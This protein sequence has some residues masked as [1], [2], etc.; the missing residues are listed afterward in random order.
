MIRRWLGVRPIHLCILLSAFTRAKSELHSVLGCTEPLNGP[1]AEY[2]RHFKLKSR[3]WL[4]N[5]CVGFGYFRAAFLQPDHRKPYV[6]KIDDY[7]EIAE[8]IESSLQVSNGTQMGDPKKG[9]HVVRG[10]SVARGKEF[11]QSLLMGSDCFQLCAGSDSGIF[12][13]QDGVGE[14]F[15]EHRFLNAYLS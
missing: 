3:P 5:I 10:E 14:C 13:A 12:G 11:P 2:P 4:R 1:C 6:A 7:R 15:E 9:V 8:K